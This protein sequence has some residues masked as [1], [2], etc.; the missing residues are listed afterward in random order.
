MSSVILTLPAFY[1]CPRKKE[2][3]KEKKK[4]KE[5]EEDRNRMYLEQ[6]MRRKRDRQCTPAYVPQHSRFARA[7]FL[8]PSDRIEARS[9]HRLIE[10]ENLVA[11]R[12]HRDK[13]E[14][15]RYTCIH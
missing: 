1:F 3:K 8:N 14:R 13:R 10:T 6:H 5:E 12:V 4:Q 2:E 15:D 9:K 7:R 11:Y